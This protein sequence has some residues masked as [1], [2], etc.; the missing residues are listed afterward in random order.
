MTGV[1]TCALPIWTNFKWTTDYA[2]KNPA[3]GDFAAM[4]TEEKLNTFAEENARLDEQLLARAK[5]ILTPE[6]YAAYQ[7]YQEQQR[8]MKIAGMKIAAQMFRK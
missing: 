2:N 7:T 1:Q 6:Q 8:A 5:P 3:N 4:F